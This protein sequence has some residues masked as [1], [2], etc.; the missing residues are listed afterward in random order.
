LGQV[1]QTANQLLADLCKSR[2]ALRV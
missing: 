2:H 1:V